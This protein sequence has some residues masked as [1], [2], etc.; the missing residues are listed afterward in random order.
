VLLAAF[1]DAV[2]AG[3]EPLLQLAKEAVTKRT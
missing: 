3:A 2:L 1:V